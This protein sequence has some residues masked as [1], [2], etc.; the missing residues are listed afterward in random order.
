[1]RLFVAFLTY[2]PRNADT[3]RI[4]FGSPDILEIVAVIEG[5]GEEERE[6]EKSEHFDLEKSLRSTRFPLEKGGKIRMRI[7]EPPEEPQTVSTG[8]QMKN[9]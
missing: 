2:P 9:T 6:L 5:T 4:D 1:M 8:D 3:K 7:P